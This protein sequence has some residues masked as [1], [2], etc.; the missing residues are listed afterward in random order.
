MLSISENC[1]VVPILFLNLNSFASVFKNTSV[2]VG[3]I[4]KGQQSTIES[5]RKIKKKV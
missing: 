4:V 2:F 3:N 1:M 5:G